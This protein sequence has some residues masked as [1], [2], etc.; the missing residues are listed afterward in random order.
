MEN[1]SRAELPTRL[2]ERIKSHGA[3]SF[4]D[5]MQAALYDEHDGYYRRRDIKRWG[6]EGDYRTSPE[7]SPLFASTFARFFH[8][9]YEELGSPASWTIHEAGAGAGHFAQGVLET[10][11]S[12]YPHLLAA[13]RYVVDEMNT[14]ARSFIQEKLAR[15]ARHVE[16]A[17]LSDNRVT[18]EHGIVFA[19]ELLDA[20]PVHRVAVEGGQLRE[21]FIATD[22]AGNFIWTSEEPSTPLI[23]EYL[24]RLN[25]ELAEGQMAEINLQ[26]IDWLK[27]AVTMFNRGYLIL[28]DYGAEAEEL[29]D[30][31]LRPRGSLRAFG[32]HQLIDDALREPGEYD[33]TTTIDW[34]TVK[35]V[36]REA[37]L[38][39][40]S[41]ERQDRFLLRAG[42]LEELAHTMTGEVTDAASL[43]IRATAREMI[44]PGGMSESFQ[45]L[46]AKR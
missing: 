43:K 26:A 12:S 13:T 1:Q 20:F 19:N 8:K 17:N 5:W 46:V 24:R 42:L 40:V 2:R 4:H 45:V 27:R 16:Y 6:R 41:F 14:D 36:C 33:I 11:N 3:I 38:E 29:Y 7:R 28:V 25:V 23:A 32:R 18:L 21:L 39:I 44:L 10:F 30:V 34:T 35:R 31:S 9:L 37:G 22:E 15:F